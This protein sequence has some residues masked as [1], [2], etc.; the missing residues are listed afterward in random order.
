[1]KPEDDPALAALSDFGTKM[2]RGRFM[3]A[4]PEEEQREI[5]LLISPGG[6]AEVVSDTGAEPAE[7]PEEE[8]AEV[9]AEPDGDEMG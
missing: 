3:D 5:T 2:R 8:A 6:V 7:T 4:L 9:E 1:M